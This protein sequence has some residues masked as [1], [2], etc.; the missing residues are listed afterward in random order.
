MDA[1]ERRRQEVPLDILADSVIGS[2]GTTKAPALALESNGILVGRRTFCSKNWRRLDC[3]HLQV[4]Q[5]P[6]AMALSRQAA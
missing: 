3:R 1:N 6:A 2:T 5:N 4:A